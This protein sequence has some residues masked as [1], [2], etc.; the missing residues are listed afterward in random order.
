[1]PHTSSEVASC[2]AA[3]PARRGLRLC[4][5]P[6]GPLGFGRRRRRAWDVMGRAASR[7]SD[8]TCGGL[9]RACDYC[10]RCASQSGL[11][12]A[13]QTHGC[14]WGRRPRHDSDVRNRSAR[15]PSPETSAFVPEREPGTGATS[16]TATG[17]RCLCEVW[18]RQRWRDGNGPGR[19]RLCYWALRTR[20]QRN[21]LSA[22]NPGRERSHHAIE[23]HC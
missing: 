5:R 13:P 6:P 12:P 7:A 8:G 1:M 23:P 18:R 3:R 21:S 16:H 2:A 10:V 15:S 22:S 20:R 17:P 14:R 9:G 4:E 11:A 19:P